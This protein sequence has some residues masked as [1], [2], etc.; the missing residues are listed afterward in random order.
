MKKY[1]LS[2]LLLWCG[3]F[4]QAQEYISLSPNPCTIDQEGGTYTFEVEYSPS[5]DSL[6]RLDY[7]SFSS[8]SSQI[9]SV[10]QSGS[11]E[12]TIT[13]NT[14]SNPSLINGT[15]TVY[16]VDPRDISNRI[17]G[18]ISFAQQAGTPDYS[19][20]ITPTSV[21]F[22]TKGGS[23]TFQVSYIYMQE[24]VQLTYLGATGLPDGCSVI[25]K[26]NGIIELICNRN[27][28]KIEKNSTVTLK[29]TNPVNPSTP[30]TV[31][32]TLQ[33]AGLN[34]SL[35]LNPNFIS[36]SPN[37][38]WLNIQAE[39]DQYDTAYTLHL[40]HVE[41]LPN[42]AS[43]EDWVGGNGFTITF[44]ANMTGQT[45]T[46][47][48]T[49]AFTDPSDAN[50]SIYAELSYE[51]PSLLSLPQEDGKVIEYTYRN[52][53]GNSYNTSV[54]H[55][56]GLGRTIQMVNVGASPQGGDLISFVTYDCMGRSDSVSYLPYV[57]T[58]SGI[59]RD[60]TPVSSQHT[61]YAQKFGSNAA[62]YAKNLKRYDRGLGLVEVANTPG[63]A[64]NLTSGYYTRYTYRLN[65]TA[66]A[67]K[68]YVVLTNGSLQSQGVYEADQLTVYRTLNAQDGNS[69]QQQEN[70]EYTDALG[71]TIASEVRVSDQDRR[72]TY[73]VYDDLN[74]LRYILPPMA[75]TYDCSTPKTA[76][77]LGDYCYYSEYD[78]RGNIIKSQNPGAEYSL[79]IYDRR[80]RLVMSQ[81]GK[82]RINNEWSFTKYDV[83]DR[84]VLSGIITGGTY[85]SHK[86]ALDAATVFYEERGTTVHGYTNQSYPSVPNANSYLT[87]TYYDD[88]DWLAANDPH[89]FSTA[90]A[91][92]QTHTTD[93]VG[94]TTGVKNKVLGI[95]TDQWLTTVTYYDQKYQTIQAISD[96]YPSGTEITSNTHD[97][98]GN[99][100]Q[101]KVKQSVGGSTYEYNKWFNYD[102]FGRLL[103]IQQQITGDATNGKVTLVSYTYDNLGNVASKSIHNGAETET[104]TYDLNGRVI[105][106]T[107]PS[108][109]YTLDYE[110]SDLPGATPRLD[111]Q[112][113]ALR[114]GAGQTP[115][116]AY[117]YTYDPVGQLS[118]AAYKTATNGTWSASNAYAEKNLTY[119]RHGNIKTLQRTDANGSILHELSDM[120]Y[121]GNKL[122]S[123]KL[124][125]GSP[126]N[127]AYDQNG[128]ITSDGRRGVTINYNI[129]NFPEQIIAGNQQVSY[130][131]SAAGEKLATNANGSLTYYRSVMVYGND[132]KLLHILTPEGTVS[133]TEGSAGTNYTYNYFKKDQI[134]STRA[135]LS[136][137]GNSLQNVQSTD[138]YPF[139]LAYSTNNL[140]K[141]KYLFS[142]KELQDASI[143]GTILGLYDFGARQYDPV[144]GRWMSIDL[145]ANKFP[146]VSPFVYCLNNPINLVDLYGLEP[147]EDST[148]TDWWNKIYYL[149]NIEISAYNSLNT[150]LY[151]TINPTRAELLMWYVISHSMGLEFR[152][153]IGNN[154]NPISPDG[155]A[156][157]TGN[158]IGNNA[159]SAKNK[160]S[161]RQ[162]LI[163]KSELFR[164]QLINQIMERINRTGRLTFADAT[165]LWR[166]GYGQD[167][168]VDI[169]T[170]DLSRVRLSDV[171][172]GEISVNLFGLKHIHNLNDGL[173][174]GTITLVQSKENPFE[175]AA[176]SDEYNFDIKPEGSVL[177]NIGTTLGHG[178]GGWG[179]THFTIKFTGTVKIT[180]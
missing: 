15:V 20:K 26:A 30:L 23:Q 74:R 166:Y 129:L 140:N 7:V 46:G 98:L 32:F 146:D 39:L 150:A 117:A 50:E 3:Y 16:F 33:Q 172:N 99:V 124:N 29:Y 71:R 173:V 70:L 133:R 41:N 127:Y 156:P 88:Y 17:Y 10:V 108:F 86:A 51:Q 106:S 21:Y 75:D 92:G 137:V 110:Q 66:D 121:T 1:I 93:V 141:N 35:I 104:Y 85:E 174:H 40:Q 81:S 112:I 103:S 44:P 56:D 90:D 136:A 111:G 126:V 139:G 149:M 25:S 60:A 52:E 115:N 67:I 84:P 165:L 24:P 69:S 4:L 120:T 91:L 154:N 76:Q 65:T 179:G 28:S 49:V 73:Y 96:L 144:I 177:R 180:R 59:G 118:A 13:F 57:R 163:N 87:V 116:R 125:G 62:N 31:S 68:R 131:Y 12:L 22:D 152:N 122:Q 123:L 158:R 148:D 160:L 83:F 55:L 8:T 82:Q 53:N 100:T 42:K 134:G 113:T 157:S 48:A 78:E 19:L 79:A 159:K 135:V 9:N 18:T 105:A 45:L 64:H 54:N 58:T 6:D 101:T 43:T 89:A 151:E 80:G 109:S 36:V 61:F 175:F 153:N 130:I 95:S 14:N 171:K 178:V 114:W 72:I 38:E 119:D 169:N 162:K 161:L 34:Y 168:T 2:I 147:I 97:F 138:Y 5:P 145:L 176:S 77:Q 102:N 164:K 142:G 132:N 107:S 170:I 37:G 63:E 94:L 143:G 47:V 27:P 155:G 167:V 128:N 11:K